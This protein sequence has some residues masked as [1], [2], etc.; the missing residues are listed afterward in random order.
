MSDLIRRVVG[1]IVQRI[2]LALMLVVAA[3][4]RFC[5]C[6]NPIPYREQVGWDR[7]QKVSDIAFGEPVLDSNRLYIP[8]KQTWKAGD[9]VTVVVLTGK[10]DNNRIVITGHR[11]LVSDSKGKDRTG[12]SVEM[13][14]SFPE[15]MDL[16]YVD[17][18]G[19]E[20]AV[21]QVRL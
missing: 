7:L 9:S 11:M 5:G 8:V 14:E 4:S 6:A 16:V 20:Q 17:P 13:G 10:F 21:G 15:T 2:F 1:H 18:D 19:C 12:I 3:G